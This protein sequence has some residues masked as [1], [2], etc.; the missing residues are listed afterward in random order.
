MSQEDRLIYSEQG[1]EVV[2][3]LKNSQTFGR[4]KLAA[5]ILL[6]DAD[7]FRLFFS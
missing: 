1:K 5:D 3:I 6:V 7:V 4:D 2:I